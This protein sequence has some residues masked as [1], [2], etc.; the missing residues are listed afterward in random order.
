MGNNNT[1]SSKPN[2][3]PKV[4]QAGHDKLILQ[5]RV[6]SIIIHYGYKFS[7]QIGDV[8]MFPHGLSGLKLW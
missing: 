4:I 1:N 5:L 8:G 6:R 3:Q 2:Q 7:L